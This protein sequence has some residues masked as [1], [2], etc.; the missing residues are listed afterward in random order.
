MKRRYAR[1]VTGAFLAVSLMLGGGSF[2]PQGVLPLP[3]SAVVAE[4]AVVDPADASGF[5]VLSEV[6]PD[7]I[8]E[9]RY[10]STYNFVGDRIRGYNEPV[11][12]MTK[13][14]ASALKDVADELREKGYRLKIFDAYRPQ[15]AVDNFKEWALDMKDTRMKEYFYPD[16]P[17]DVLFDQGYIAARSGHSRG[18]TVDLT[19]FDMRTEKEVDMGGTFDFF[20]ERSHPDFKGDLTP[21]QLKNRRI[22]SQAMFRHG[23]KGLD[24][25]WWHFT[26]RN[27]PYPET[28]FTFPNSAESVHN[29]D[30]AAYSPVWV[31]KL[32]AAA[33]A[34]Q[35]VVVAGVS[36]QTAWISLHEK[37]REGNWQQVLTT[38]G[39]IG[40]E[41]LGKTK[42]GDGRTPV[43]TFHFT[44]AFGICPNPGTKLPYTQVDENI[45]WSG[46][47]RPGK[48]YNEMVDIRQIPDLNQ[49][50][51]EHI[52]DYNPH[53]K[54]CLNISYN[55]EGTPGKGS[56]IFMHCFG[57]NKP[58]TGGCVSL[59]EAKMKALIQRVE[60]GCAVVIDSL[61]NM[62]G[63]L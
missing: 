5:V 37:D 9:I 57:P 43:G 47:V 11:A 10:Y 23:F 18:S 3:V 44:K 59:P 39:F 1:K 25:E 52:V 4:A 60:P 51:S 21:E 55:E 22:L 56:A 31:T 13:E 34:K 62:G 19:L 33:K 32:P 2:L 26:L 46:D 20:G 42:E 48:H 6:V 36:K 28:Y 24:T 15:M 58:F 41:G 29:V 14:A 54:Y 17:K 8:Q 30:K 27:E 40:K 38:P 50:N 7:V 63:A 53:Y 49:E 61:E 35:M 45:Y 16:L 12:L